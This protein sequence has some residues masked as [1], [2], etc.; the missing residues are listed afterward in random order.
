MGVSA[1]PRSRAGRRWLL[2]SGR[3][4]QTRRAFGSPLALDRPWA[5]APRAAVGWSRPLGP[6]PGPGRPRSRSRARMTALDPGAGLR[7]L[8]RSGSHC[9]RLSVVAMERPRDGTGR[10]GTGRPGT[11]EGRRSHQRRF[12][13]PCRLAGADRGRPGGWRRGRG[14]QRALRVSCHRSSSCRGSTAM[15][16]LV[17]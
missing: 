9:P 13:A 17:F 3:C 14:A 4:A 6:P 7:A 15:L 2:S 10:P 12:L 1:R 16:G 5:R 8:A 11:S